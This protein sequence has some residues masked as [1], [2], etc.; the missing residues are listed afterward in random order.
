MQ[1]RKKPVVAITGGSGFLGNA[2]VRHFLEQG[3]SVKVLSRGSLRNTN[4]NLTYV[5]Y[6]MHEKLDAGVL[7]NVDYLVHAAYIKQDRHNPKAFDINI[8]AAK[9]LYAA[10]K[11]SHV[12]KC[13]FMSSMSAHKQAISSYAKQ[14]L[15]IEKIFSGN[16]SISIR[17][18]LIVGNGGIVKQMIGFMR[19]KHM[20]PLVGGGKQP[21]Q[22]VSV[23]DLVIVIDKLLTS[24]L[25]GVL[26][27]ATN[28]V[29]SYKQFYRA[30]A[31]QLDIKVLFIPIPFFVLQTMIRIINGLHLPLAINN[32]NLLGLKALR[33]VDTRSDLNKVGVK[34]RS[35]EIALGSIK[36]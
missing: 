28:E 3:W 26:T 14:K 36:T 17:A 11:Q 31:K 27:I 19:S 4:K 21:L 35:L 25:S 29:Y 32:D 18:G 30:I 6:D 12:K 22:I 23:D 24:R 10:A 20:V 9:Q 2:L 33:S 13:L 7:S 1:A 8:S 34:L 16:N 15:A 5:H